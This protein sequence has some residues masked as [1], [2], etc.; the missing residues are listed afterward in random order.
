V[1]VDVVGYSRLMGLDESGTLARLK[2][3]RRELIDG[4]IA[5][6]S[7]R[8]VKTTGDGLLLEFSS[9]VDAVNCAVDIQRGMAERNAGVPSEHKIQF[10]VGINVG[11]VIVDDDDIF[12]DGVNIAVRI[13]G[14][15]E[16]GKICVSKV[17]RDHVHDKLPYV[18]E[19]IGAQEVKNI[20]LPVEVFRLDPAD[21]DGSTRRL[22]R[23]WNRIRPS[24]W[25]RA[26]VG[27][28]SIVG[29]GALFWVLPWLQVSSPIRIPP[30]MSVA[31]LP[32]AAQS[33]NSADQKVADDVTR[34]MTENLERLARYAT[35]APYGV[36]SRYKNTP[37]VA[38]Q[39][40]AQLNVRYLVAGDVRHSG[41]DVLVDAKLIDASDARQVW[42]D[43]LRI[44][45]HDVAGD[46]GRV[47]AK[48]NARARSALAS[49]E[50]RRVAG[51]LPP[52]ASPL[53]MAL[54]AAAN[55]FK[56]QDRVQGLRVARELYDAALRIDSHLLFALV[57]RAEGVGQELGLNPRSD[58][59]RLVRE[60]DEY[61]ARAVHQDDK[62]PRAWTV[63]ARALAWQHRWDASLEA[64]ANVEKLDP[65]RV[66]TF[67]HRAQVLIN[68][69]EPE[70]ALTK[71]DEMKKLDLPDAE[72]ASWTMFLR[73]R[74]FLA[75]GRYNDAIA[76]CERSIAAG[77]NWW[78]VY[79]YLVA[80]YAQKG[81][82][83]RAAAERVKLEAYVPGFSIADFN[84]IKLSDKQLYQAQTE[85]HL[86]AGLRKAGVPER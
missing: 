60:M 79:C 42:S 85:R 69:G 51:P 55:Q 15:A 38:Q 72:W 53:E 3:H 32:F 52:D 24:H 59:D 46:M 78:M 49:A 19:D 30:A 47:V 62:D 64:T 4:S 68:L 35:V 18:F 82:T 28:L 17:V 70:R 83:A 2:L 48:L 50:M 43:Q 56:G 44:A 6:H 20:A 5:K 41:E 73:C 1:S 74:A 9:V 21:S 37:L 57:N 27:V 76:S 11:D 29:A 86:Y 77:E 14:L 31:V 12:G 58:R 25:R 63:R 67:A 23:W 7:G 61:S 39:A 75:L 13:E 33:E 81:D 36:A 80:A 66:E 34:A 8:I 71:L 54:H 65:A 26:G 16:P 22:G 45:R 10:R 40:G 84:A